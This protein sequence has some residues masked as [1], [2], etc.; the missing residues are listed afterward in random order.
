MSE[1]TR[2]EI[3]IERREMVK[4]PLGVLILVA[5][6]SISLGALGV[7]TLKLKQELSIKE[8]EI[9]LKG[10]NYKKEKTELLKKIKE[11]KKE[12]KALESKFESLTNKSMAK[13]QPT[14]GKN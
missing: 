10:Q 14:I 7:Y 8:Q 6:L 13:S 2:L 5:F 3:D 11:L 12:H 9:V 4:K 1:K